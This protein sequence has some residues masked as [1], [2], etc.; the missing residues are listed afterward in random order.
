MVPRRATRLLL[1]LLRTT[2][3]RCA[4]DASAQPASPRRPRSG[5]GVT[6]AVICLLAIGLGLIARY[7]RPPE[8][9]TAAERAGETLW[10]EAECGSCHGFG[11]RAGDTGPNLEGVLQRLGT[12]GVRRQVMSGRGDMPAHDVTAN[13]LDHLVAYLAYLDRTGEHPPPHE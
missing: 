2:R 11:R 12:N 10:V 9:M 8:E 7:R 1:V 13:D 4:V 3:H 6:L 5:P